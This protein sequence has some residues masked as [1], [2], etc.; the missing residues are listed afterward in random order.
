MATKSAN[1]H[2]LRIWFLL[3]AILILLGAGIPLLL[4]GAEDPYVGPVDDGSFSEPGIDEPTGKQES[5]V[6]EA[7]ADRNDETGYSDAPEKIAGTTGVIH[8]SVGLG[9]KLIDKVT[10]CNLVLLE[11]INPNKPTSSPHQPRMIRKRLAF[12]PTRRMANFRFEDVPLS[13]YGWNLRVFSPGVNGSEQIVMLTE[14]DSVKTA[15]LDLRQAT[16]LRINLKD[17]QYHPVAKVRV[18][19]KPSGSD[20]M[21]RP[22][23]PSNPDTLT[24]NSGFLLIENVLAGEYEMLIGDPSQ[25]LIPPKKVVIGSKDTQLLQVEVPRGGNAVFRVSMPGGY[26]APDVEVQAVAKDSKVYR[27]RKG[28]TDRTGRLTL[29]HLPAGNYFVY[30]TKKGFNQ[31]FKEVVVPASGKVEHSISLNLAR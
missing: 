1:S 21:G 18:Y 11:A 27:Q 8:G 25:P 26:G 7:A 23:Y 4:P 17:Q 12:E 24:D 19:L 29:E 10:S 28:K 9:P 3:G 2:S 13:E 30:F 6:I 14:E 31:A 15:H 16:S 5:R 22:G 20:L